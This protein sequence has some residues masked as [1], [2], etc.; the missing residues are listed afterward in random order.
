M[1]LLQVVAQAA[2]ALLVLYTAHRYGWNS[3]AVG[4]LLMVYSVGSI[5]VMAA[6]APLIV[7]ALGDRLVVLL[8]IACSIAGFFGLALAPSGTWFCVAVGAVCL[9]SVSGPAL[10]ALVTQKVDP[11]EQG[12]LHGALGALMALGSFA[13]PI[14]FTQIFAWSILSGSSPSKL[15]AA[16]AAAGLLMIGAWI[17]AFVFARGPARARQV[18]VRAALRRDEVAEPQGFDLENP[19][20]HRSSAR[21][22][23]L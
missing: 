13:G 9:G 5:A 1:T 23:V 15:G 14:A 12:R 3:G 6:I 10:T 4:V 2:N 21:D 18:E 17:L 7:K 11:G 19:A 16:M 20:A 22:D 8:G